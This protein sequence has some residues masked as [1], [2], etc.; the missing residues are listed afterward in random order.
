[1]EIPSYVDFSASKISH[2]FWYLSGL[3]VARLEPGVGDAVD[4]SVYRPGPWEEC[5]RA[6]QPPL[7]RIP[8]RNQRIGPMTRPG[9]SLPSNTY[10]SSGWTAQ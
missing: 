9:V 7:L 2:S 8:T 6:L 4:V 3:E 5:P 10:Y 1:M